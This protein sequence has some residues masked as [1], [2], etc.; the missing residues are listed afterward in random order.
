[1]KG[2]NTE[3]F[4]SG[5][6]LP[7]FTARE[8]VAGCPRL[9]LTKKLGKSQ[10]ENFKTSFPEDLKEDLKQD[11]REKIREKVIE[12]VS[13]KVKEKVKGKVKEHSNSA[14][15]LAGELS[16]SDHQAELPLHEAGLDEKLDEKTGTLQIEIPMAGLTIFG[17]PNEAKCPQHKPQTT[18]RMQLEGTESAQAVCAENTEAIFN[19]DQSTLFQPR[20][21]AKTKQRINRAKPSPTPDIEYS[22]KHLEA[23]MSLAQ[24]MRGKAKRSPVSAKKIKALKGLGPDVPMTDL[25]LRCLQELRETRKFV[26]HSLDSLSGAGSS[27]RGY[28]P[29]Q[30]KS[31]HGMQ[32]GYQQS[33]IGYTASTA[34]MEWSKATITRSQVERKIRTNK[35]KQERE[36]RKQAGILICRHLVAALKIQAAHDGGAI[37]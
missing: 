10:S 25:G 33:L 13:E 19:D 3:I 5:E 36:S 15:V 21:P 27:C 28:K 22:T 12:K 11:P 14:V 18:A 29:C 23:A 30:Q 26:K 24:Q 6:T 16:S 35:K 4:S 20:E 1:M 32:M 34:E 31:D 17:A 7:L 8:L 37:S 2:E 9:S